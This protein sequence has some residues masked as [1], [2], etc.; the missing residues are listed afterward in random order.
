MISNWNLWIIIINVF[1]L[2][3]LVLY[4]IFSKVVTMSL[5]PPSDAAARMF[6]GVMIYGGFFW[7][8]WAVIYYP[9]PPTV[10]DILLV[11]I[12]ALITNFNSVT[13]YFFGSSSGSTVKDGVLAAQMPN[14]VS[15]LPTPTPPTVKVDTSDGPVAVT[16]TKGG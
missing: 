14:P 3:F 12:G 2:S 8:L 7:A 13:Q 10:H 6:L 16:E 1:V 11:F 5:A 9:L 4:F 15:P